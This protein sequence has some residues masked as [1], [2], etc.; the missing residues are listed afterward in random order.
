VIA[1]IAVLVGIV[2]PALA[3]ARQA[4]AAVHCAANLRSIGQAMRGFA[5][6]HE[7]RFPGSA[8]GAASYN[9]D[10]LLNREYFKNNAAK[11]GVRVTLGVPDGAA[12][13]CPSFVVTKSSRQSLVMNHNAAGG[14]VSGTWP[15]GP[16]GLQVTNP[17][18]VNA[19][20]T[21]SFRLGAKVS[22]F[23]S[24]SK[25]FLVIEQEDTANYFQAKHPYDDKPSTW[26]LG[27]N[28][29]APVWAGNDGAFSF[30]HGR[31]GN[32]RG[33]ALFVDGHVEVITPKDEINT[34][35]R[36]NLDQW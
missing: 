12:I 20:Y 30:R 26:S 17:V 28:P 8:S 14:Q 9:W 4:S 1:V 36:W 19:L 2:M 18:S 33:N 25:K 11:G 3:K 10:S 21:N 6:A 35:R 15:A 29:N 31:R 22:K 7:D 24:S 13:G 32:E 34:R 27:D 16:H 5:I 23:K